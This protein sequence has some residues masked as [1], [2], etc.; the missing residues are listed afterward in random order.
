M[1][2][3]SKL[4]SGNVESKLSLRLDGLNKYY[5]GPIIIHLKKVV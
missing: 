5:N 3:V 4:L 1:L 2:K